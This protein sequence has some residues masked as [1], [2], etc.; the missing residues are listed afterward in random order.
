MKIEKI[1][2]NM[3]INDEVKDIRQSER[4]TL[5][6]S[7]NEGKAERI[8]EEKELR[9]ITRICNDRSISTKVQMRQIIE[10]MQEDNALCKMLSPVQQEQL[11]ELFLEFFHDDAAG[12]KLFNSLKERVKE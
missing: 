6:R 9:E 10:V 12:R 4:K 2:T 1:Y 8:Q 3:G 7:N 11:M 5:F